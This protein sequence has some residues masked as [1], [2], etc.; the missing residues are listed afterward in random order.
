MHAQIKEGKIKELKMIIKA[1]VQGSLEAIK[2]T[3]NK[4]NVS[5]IKL[6]IIHEA[7]GSINSSD[8]ILA[9]AS[10]ALILGFNV[11]RMNRQKN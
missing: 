1:D 2:Q 11:M 9:V 8:V 5:E 7:V 4:L 10:D 3:L 6:N